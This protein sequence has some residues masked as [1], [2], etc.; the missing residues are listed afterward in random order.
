MKRPQSIW[1]G[2]D[3][4]AIPNDITVAAVARTNIGI[5]SGLR[6]SRR[7]D[8][9]PLRFR[10]HECGSSV[11][12]AAIR[13]GTGRHV[14]RPEGLSGRH[15]PSLSGDQAIGFRK[16]RRR[17]VSTTIPVGLSA[18]FFALNTAVRFGFGLG[19]A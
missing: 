16:D 19:S 3:L 4:T 8:D 2:I 18:V 12:I 10:Q 7:R 11:A 15:K 1:A 9:R 14:L 13:I 17:F 5:A 6:S